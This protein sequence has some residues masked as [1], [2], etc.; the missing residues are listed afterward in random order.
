MRFYEYS[1]DFVFSMIQAVNIQASSELTLS[2]PG[3][4]VYAMSTSDDMLFAGAHVSS[5]N[6]FEL[7][8]SYIFFLFVFVRAAVLVSKSASHLLCL[9][10]YILVSTSTGWVDL[11]VDFQFWNQLI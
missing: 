10:S 2:A 3:R 4:Q 6:M 9:I 8:Y 11:G 5:S 1:L 7:P